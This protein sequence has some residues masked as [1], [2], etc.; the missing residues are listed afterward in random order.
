MHR[1]QQD[2]LLLTSSEIYPQ[3]YSRTPCPVSAY[4]SGGLIKTK[5][6]WNYFKF[7]KMRDFFISYDNQVLLRITS[8]CGPRS[9]AL[10]RKIFPLQFGKKENTSG[11]SV[12]R[13]VYW[14]VSKT[15]KVFPVLIDRVGIGWLTLLW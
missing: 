7:H 10:P 11:N 3:V 14:F 8:Q 2:S 6:A 9:C 1:W 4:M 12:E 5:E 13:R 15:A